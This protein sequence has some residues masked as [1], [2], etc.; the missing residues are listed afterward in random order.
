MLFEQQISERVR[1]PK[2]NWM[3]LDVRSKQAAFIFIPLYPTRLFPSLA[4]IS[5][6]MFL[7]TALEAKARNNP[8][9]SLKRQRYI[10]VYCSNKNNC[11]E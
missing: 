10:F 3:M 4:K 2:R 5:C 8:P 9:L 1:K 7:A 6:F 11:H